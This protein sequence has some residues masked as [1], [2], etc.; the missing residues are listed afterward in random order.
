MRTRVG[1]DGFQRLG[2]SAFDGEDSSWNFWTLG[3]K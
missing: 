2:V 3:E 1:T